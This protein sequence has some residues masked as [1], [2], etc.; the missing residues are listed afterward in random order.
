MTQIFIEGLGNVEIS[1]NVPT[2][3]EEQAIIQQLQSSEDSLATD[4]ITPEM[5]TPSLGDEPK[6]QGLEFIGGRPTF[7]ATGALAG[8]IPGTV[9]GGLPGSVAGGT[10]GAMGGGQ[11][12]D[13]I[14]S[15]LTDEE[16][17]FG[18]QIEAAKKDFQRE[19]L[20]QSFFSKIPGIGTKL[21]TAI[22]GKPNKE[23]YGSAKRMN[24]PLSLSDSG[25]MISKGYGRV[26]GVFPYVGTPIKKQFAAKAD[27]INKT[28]DDTL[29]LFAP[30]V[31]LTK[32]GIDMAEAS[33]STYGDFRRISGL[34][35][36]DFYDTAQRVK[37]PIIP[38]DTF[39]NSLKNYIN[40]ID[41]GVI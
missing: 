7:E 14:Q 26:I 38:T 22:F 9:A 34:L 1:G 37:A 19:A 35:Y 20:L 10:L 8:G 12:Y 30:N 41:D 17:G 31:N 36:D 25:N 21:K 4:T 40:L 23:L 28:A 11:I 5:V 32:L 29:N 3:E 6:L 33:K 24:F 39:K 16:I 15:N 27:I 2:K 13:I 18:T